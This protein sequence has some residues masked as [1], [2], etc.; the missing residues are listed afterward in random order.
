M[1]KRRFAVLFAVVLGALAALSVIVPAWGDD[2]DG[3]KKLLIGFQLE[4]TGP[5]TTAGTFQAAGAVKD[6]GASNVSGLK[7][8][9]FGK[10]AKA[11]L[12]GTQTFTG[13][14]GTIVTEFKGVAHDVSQRH[15]YGK[16]RF[17]IVSG[18]GDYA[19][20]EGKGRFLIVVD[21]EANRLTGT[22]KG[23]AR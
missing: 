13:E 4:F 20:L 18:T 22:E 11:R 16:G 8:E 15:Q 12:S 23:H 7:L 3:G 2:D 10:R 17:R 1:S 9:P 21:R 19:G 5:D 14:R 6:S